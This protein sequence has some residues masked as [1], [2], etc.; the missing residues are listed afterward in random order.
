MAI[1]LR[2]FQGV[3]NA[4]NENRFKYTVRKV[5]YSRQ[6]YYK[7]MNDKEKNILGLNEKENI[8]IICGAKW[9]FSELHKAL[10]GFDK[11]VT[12][13]SVNRFYKNTLAEFIKDGVDVIVC[14]NVSGEGIVTSAKMFK[15]AIFKELWER[16]Q[17]KWVFN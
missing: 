17:E 11:D 1:N 9:F 12:R 7:V 5:C 4:K 6:V 16:G 10:G 13:E 14:P 8:A 3:F 2:E 15:I